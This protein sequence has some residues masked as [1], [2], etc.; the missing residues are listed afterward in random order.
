MIG[1]RCWFPPCCW[2]PATSTARLLVL[3]KFDTLK[4]RARP[5]ARARGCRQHQHNRPPAV[6]LVPVGCSLAAALPVVLDAES[7]AG[8]AVVCR[9][10]PRLDGMPAAST[11][12]PALPGCHYFKLSSIGKLTTAP[13][14]VVPQAF[15]P[16]REDRRGVA[17][18]AGCLR[19]APALLLPRR[20]DRRGLM[21]HACSLLGSCGL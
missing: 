14:L 4:K 12:R 5:R 7:R 17:G 2:M 8:V 21:V 18:C 16:R 20:E 11:S 9:R 19:A 3:Y 13:P 1:C 15:P 6:C 10:S